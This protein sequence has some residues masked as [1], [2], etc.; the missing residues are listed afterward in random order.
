MKDL[1][2]VDGG[3]SPNLADIKM[4]KLKSRMFYSHLH[5]GWEL[6]CRPRENNFIMQ[7]IAWD[8]IITIRRKHVLLL[9][10][11]LKNIRSSFYQPHPTPA[12]PWH[13]KGKKL[14]LQ[15]GLVDKRRPQLLPYSFILCYHLLWP[16]LLTVELCTYLIPVC[17]HVLSIHDQTGPLPQRGAIFIHRHYSQA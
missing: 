9:V 16:K 2:L 1:I 12:H 3:T 6:E 13:I 7:T 10:K 8:W 5:S 17:R 11:V 14:S 15:I 4:Y